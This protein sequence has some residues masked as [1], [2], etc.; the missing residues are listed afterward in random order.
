MMI[1]VKKT[2]NLK[3]IKRVFLHEKGQLSEMV[4]G[5]IKLNCS[6]HFMCVLLTIYTDIHVIPLKSVV[7]DLPNHKIIPLLLH[8]CNFAT[9]M[10]R[11]VNI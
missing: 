6:S 10:N 9:V 3:F 11:N 8:N 7:L 2:V 4:G 5:L 1:I